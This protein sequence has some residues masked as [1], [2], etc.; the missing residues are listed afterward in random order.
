M[1]HGVGSHG[2]RVMVIGVLTGTFVAGTPLMAVAAVQPADA[3][4][5]AA[6]KAGNTYGGVT[7]QG[8]PVV[9]DMTSN[10]RKLVRAMAAMELPCTS[11]ATAFLPDEYTGLPVTKKGKFGTAFGPLTV[12]N[13][14]GT[15]TDIEGRIS[16]KLNA[17]K[18]KIAGGWQ[19]SL[20][21]RDAAG[22]VTDTCVSGSVTW[23]AK[24]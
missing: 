21:D 20:T 18:T 12:R 22:A 2:W 19:L 1:A 14:D 9:V 24:Q 11:G 3:R 8:Y 23:K 6:A 17:A 16:G 4:T 7:S 5:T 10:R 15:T 13:D